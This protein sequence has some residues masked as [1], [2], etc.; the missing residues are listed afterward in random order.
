MTQHA[1][2]KVKTADEVRREFSER[3]ATI[4]QW[5]R[6]NDFKKSLVFEVLAGRAKGRYGMSHRIAVMLGLKRGT[7]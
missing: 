6:D 7:L 1:A 4:S 2:H 5:A 3:G